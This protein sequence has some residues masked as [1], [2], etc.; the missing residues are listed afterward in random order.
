MAKE[1]RVARSEWT[2]I[3]GR[4]GGWYLNSPFRRLSEMLFLGDCRSAFLRA[5]SEIARGN[6]VVLD[7]GAG[8]GYFSLAL[9]TKLNAGKVICL[10]LSEEMLWRLKRKA[11]EQGQADRIQIVE[12]P[13]TASGLEPE[14]V[15]LAVSNG[16]FHELPTPD[17]VVTEMLRVSKSGGWV[18]ITD[19]RDTRVGR[20][21]G[22][23]HREGSHGPFS[24]GEMEILL[25]NAGL[26]NV[27]VRPVRHWVVG[28]GQK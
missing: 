9:V 2:G 26:R 16:L 10:D 15:D 3:K 19:F 13:A 17:A 4:I 28:V 18:I 1:Q 7:V 6:E 14:S 21:I 25:I 8:S 20:R 11:E 27:N 22:A 24:V 23:A 12:A 5:V